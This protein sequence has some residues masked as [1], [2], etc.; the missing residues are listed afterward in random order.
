M[1]RQVTGEYEVKDLILKTYN[2]LVKQ[3]WTKFSQIQLVQIHREE[4]AKADELSRVDTSDPKITKGIL[5][6]VLNR[7]N[8]AKKGGNYSL[9]SQLEKSN[10]RIFEE[11]Y[12]RNRLEISKTKDPSRQVHS[13]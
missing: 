2:G 6:E 9:C 1:V 3:L 5:V 7:P 8:T 13:H 12:R 10:Y 4:N 11:P